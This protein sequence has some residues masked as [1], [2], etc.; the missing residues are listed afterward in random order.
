MVNL[1]LL[2]I[3]GKGMDER[4]C[5]GHEQT[6]CGED[7][8]TSRQ[9]MASFSETFWAQKVRKHQNNRRMDEIEKVCTFAE[10]N[11]AHSDGCLRR[12]FI[13]I[14]LGILRDANHGEYFLEVWS[15]AKGADLLS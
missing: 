3:R 11:A 14:K 8:P 2:A 1:A 6:S 9:E 10:K 15:E 4:R 7:Y 12:G 5:I 13:R